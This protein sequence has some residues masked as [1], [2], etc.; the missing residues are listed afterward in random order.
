MDDA[1]A[2]E[3]QQQQ[4][5]ALRDRLWEATNSPEGPTAVQK[6]LSLD[7]CKLL[8]QRA[9]VVL[10]AEPTL[11]EVRAL[12]AASRSLSPSS[13]QRDGA[14]THGRALAT[15]LLLLVNR[16]SRHRKQRRRWSWATRTGTSTTWWQCKGPAAARAR[17]AACA[18]QSITAVYT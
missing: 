9:V 7:A 17:Q 8:L 1:A 2:Q 5:D 11:L 3:Q 6:A 15:P 16:S 18:R 13:S 14:A 12:G 4:L 10:K